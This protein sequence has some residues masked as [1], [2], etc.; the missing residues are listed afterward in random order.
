EI[1]MDVETAV[2]AAQ[3]LA[4]VQCTSWGHPQTSGY[5]TLDFFLRSALREP[6]NPDAHYSEKRIRLPTLSYYYEPFGDPLPPLRRE[7]I[8]LRPGGIGCW[9]GGRG[10]SGR[11][12]C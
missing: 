12:G 3:R 1:G 4:P 2:L 9:G 6:P 7:D 10:V 5:P 8:G 11:G